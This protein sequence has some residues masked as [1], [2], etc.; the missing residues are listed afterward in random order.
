MNS[1][2]H[3]LDGLSAAYSDL[4]A[5]D[6]NTPVYLENVECYYNARQGLSWV[7]GIELTAV[8]CKFNHTGKERF[9][10]SPGAGVDVEAEGSV[11]RDGKFIN[12]EFVN[13]TGVGVIADSGDSADCD[14]NGCLIWGTTNWS[15]WPRKPGFSFNGCDIYGAVVNTYGSSD[16]NEATQFVNCDFEDVQGQAYPTYGSSAILECWGENV[17]FD[18]CT[19]VANEIRALYLDDTGSTEIVKNCHI[20]HKYDGLGTGGFQSLLRGTYLENTEFHETL[21][22]GSYYINLDS[23]TVGSGVVVDGPRCK[24]QSTSGLTGTIPPGSY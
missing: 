20:Y 24:W 13:N 22:S 23:V 17:T 3:G 1:S 8:D 5:S 2:Y 10:S 4:T 12:C 21:T 15:I 11:C 19:I 14:F 16:A 9:C 18:G 7:G 6:P